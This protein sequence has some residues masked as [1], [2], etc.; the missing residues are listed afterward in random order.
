MR[1]FIKALPRTLTNVDDA[2]QL[3][4][5]SGSIGANYLEANE[6]LT[7]KDRKHRMRIARKEAKESRWWLRLLDAGNVPEVERERAA[8]EQEATELLRILS[9]IILKLDGGEGR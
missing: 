6:G 7:A 8:L 3:G 5:S 9:S 1:A 4:R 2:R